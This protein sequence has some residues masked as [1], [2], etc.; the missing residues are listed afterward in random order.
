M[1]FDD[2]VHRYRAIVSCNE[3][4]RTMCVLLVRRKIR[5]KEVRAGKRPFGGPKKAGNESIGRFGQPQSKAT[6]KSKARFGG[7]VWPLVA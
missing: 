6:L 5:K 4:Q 2:I 1:E 3:K 7:K